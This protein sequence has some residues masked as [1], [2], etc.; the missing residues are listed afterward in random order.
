MKKLNIMA[1]VILLVTLLMISLLVYAKLSDETLKI[2]DDL[3]WKHSG[4][5]CIDDDNI[6]FFNDGQI[7]WT[8]DFF[9]MWVEDDILYVKT[10]DGKWFI[11]MEKLEE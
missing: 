8:R 9:S 3:R 2:V 10:Q 6:L 5:I 1:G 4:L 7:E 11:E